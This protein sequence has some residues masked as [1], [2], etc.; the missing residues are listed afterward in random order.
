MR[1]PL[2]GAL[3]RLLAQTGDVPG[4]QFRSVPLAFA[5]FGQEYGIV[6]RAPRMRLS[7]QASLL[8]VVS[9]SIA[10]GV[11]IFAGHDVGGSLSLADVA[12]GKRFA[13]M[14]DNWLGV[15]WHL[16]LDSGAAV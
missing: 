13:L 11:E 1:L 15:A 8:W 9:S 10:C 7:R 3:S 12:D 14:N 6:A 16:N 2:E 4:L 5:V